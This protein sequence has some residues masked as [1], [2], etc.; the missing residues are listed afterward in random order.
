[1]IGIIILRD[2]RKRVPAYLV[3]LGHC[4]K[5]LNS[6]LRPFI[7]AHTRYAF[8]VAAGDLLSEISASL[9][10]RAALRK[11]KRFATPRGLK[12]HVGCSDVIKTGWVNI[13]LYSEKADLQLDARETFPFSDDSVSIVYSEHFFEHL[14][15]PDEALRFLRNSWR[16]LTPGGILS[17]GVPDL[18]VSVRAYVTGDED[19]YQHQ[20]DEKPPAWVSTPMDYLNRDFRQGREHKFAYD[21]TT[22][23][24]VLTE[25]GFVSIVRRN[26]NPELDSA[27]REWGTLYV[28]ARK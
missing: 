19:Y 16:V 4:V 11:A 20:R 3:L 27:H 9:R 22:L 10:Y 28:E 1:M 23:A 25:A 12:L 24:R 13:D 7:N 5:S 14:G 2:R 26:F 17:M 18:E 21:Y 15:Y 6:S 8:G